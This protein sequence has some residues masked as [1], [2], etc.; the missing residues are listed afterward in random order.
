MLCNARLVFKLKALSQNIKIN[1][2][3]NFKI[4]HSSKIDSSIYFSKKI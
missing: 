3:K 4:K 2:S 1:L